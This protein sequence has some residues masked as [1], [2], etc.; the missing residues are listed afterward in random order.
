[1]IFKAIFCVAVAAMLI[2]HEPD[3]GFGRPGAQTSLLQSATSWVSGSL[4]GASSATGSSS[5]ASVASA[6]NSICKDHAAACVAALGVLDSVQSVTVRGLA[7]VKADIEE[8]ERARASRT[9]GN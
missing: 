1:M 6:P 4:S 8:Q 5:A 7:Q 2:P 3:L 9:T